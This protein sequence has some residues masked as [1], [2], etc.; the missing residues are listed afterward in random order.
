MRSGI[1]PRLPPLGPQVE[2][3]Q[4]HYVDRVFSLY[5]T[6]WDFSEVFLPNL[7]LKLSSLLYLGFLA[8]KVIQ[9]IFLRDL[10]LTTRINNNNIN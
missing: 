2:P 5:P 1:F 10:G 6:T 3:H 4:G 7:N 8:S 9:V